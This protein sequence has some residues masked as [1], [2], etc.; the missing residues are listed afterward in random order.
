MSEI[1]NVTKLRYSVTH[2]IELELELAPFLTSI[3]VIL[4]LK[5]FKCSEIHRIIIFTPLSRKL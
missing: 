2:K 3:S 4:F 5:I 1:G